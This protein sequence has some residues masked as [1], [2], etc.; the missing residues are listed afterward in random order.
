MRMIKR[1]KQQTE[2]SYL[3]LLAEQTR[4]R[5]NRYLKK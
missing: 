3:R 2:T 1:T 5:R 4:E